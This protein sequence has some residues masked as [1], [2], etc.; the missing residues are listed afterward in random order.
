MYE[1]PFGKG[2]QFAHEGPLSYIVGNWQVNGITS[3][4]TGTP[5]TISAPGGSLNAPSNS[6]TADQVKSNVQRIGAVGPGTWYYDPTAFKAVTDPLRFGTTGRN[7]MRN[8]GV[9]NTDLSIFRNFPIKER[10]S[11][12]F[13]A[14]FFNFP[15]T[16]HFNGPAS[17]SVTNPNFMRILSS[18]GERQIR[19]GLRLGF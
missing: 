10:A 3:A 15:N 9:W 12:S 2:K 5:F 19:F 7:I 6:Q 17:T 4:Y 18:Y 14:E 11:L 8:P 1:L 16:S 13:R